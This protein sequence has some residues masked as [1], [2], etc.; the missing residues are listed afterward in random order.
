MNMIVPDVHVRLYADPRG[1]KDGKLS[2][3]IEIY[4]DTQEYIPL[5]KFFTPEQWEIIQDQTINQDKKKNLDR[6]TL[7]DIR[8]ELQAAINR[9]HGVIAILNEKG[10]P[11]TAANIKEQYYTYTPKGVSRLEVENIFKE[12]ILNKKE[13]KREHTTIEQYENTLKSILKFSQEKD[14][15]KLKITDITPMFLKDYEE[16]LVKDLK[17]E[18]GTVGAYCRCIRHVFKYS[19]DETKIISNDTYPFGKNKYIIPEPRKTKKAIGD[20]DFKKLLDIKDNLSYGQRRSL[21][22]FIFSFASRGLN[23]KD[24]ALMKYENIDYHSKKINV[25]REKTFRETI[26]PKEMQIE[27]LPIHNEIIEEYGNADKSKDNYIFPIIRTEDEKNKT[28]LRK[29]I[30]LCLG[31]IRRDLKIVAKKA[32]V[33]DDLTFQFARHSFGSIMKINGIDLQLISESLGHSNI[34]TTKHSIQSLDDP[35][36]KDISNLLEKTLSLSDEK[37]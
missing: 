7:H 14:Y 36:T 37:S 27:L 11:Y 4:F 33:R 29:R 26:A 16:F 30:N 17:N 25:F 34:T 3:K 24:I 1:R 22:Y 8:S 12:V 10:S 18:Y 15:K 5:K 6:N 13:A 35:R 21:I 20:D 28:S 9:I 19:I 31:N 2:I 23:F 32:G